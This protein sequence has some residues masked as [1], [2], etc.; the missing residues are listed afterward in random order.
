[1]W[2]KKSREAVPA[3]EV[4]GEFGKALDKLLP[5]PEERRRFRVWRHTRPFWAGVFVILSGIVIISYPLGPWP[6]MMAIGSSALTGIVIGLI[7]IVGGLFYWFAPHQKSFVSIILML[8][9]ILSFVASNLG[10]FFLGMI[11]GMIGSAW[12]FGWKQPK[13]VAPR[14]SPR[15]PNKTTAAAFV[16]VAMLAGMFVV[17]GHADVAEAAGR[18]L[19]RP[20]LPR[21]GCGKTPVKSGSISAKSARL[22]IDPVT[23]H[24]ACGGKQVVDL[25]IGKADLSKYTLKSPSN[26]L[27]LSSNLT[28]YNVELETPRI[29]VDLSGDLV[30]GIIP[31]SKIPGGSTVN[32]IISALIK[33]GGSVAGGVLSKLTSLTNSSGQLCITPSLIKTLGTTLYTAAGSHKDSAGRRYFPISELN[34]SPASWDQTYIRGDVLLKGANISIIG[35]PPAH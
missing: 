16:A 30:S 18:P 11:L 10:G 31:V 17:V 19:G 22:Y 35:G 27:G 6:A 26:T 14:P 23:M 3:G 33:A 32:S 21:A 24:T 5:R 2:R 28:I 9:S 29:C 1:M 8:C 25:F 4:R 12:G 20:P 13:S 7:L 34:S 15:S